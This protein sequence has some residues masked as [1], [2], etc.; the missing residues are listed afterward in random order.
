ME[1]RFKSH[2]NIGLLNLIGT[3][4]PSGFLTNGSA[5]RILKM[6]KLKERGFMLG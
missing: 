6:V 2:K 4:L 1:W 3:M 5:L